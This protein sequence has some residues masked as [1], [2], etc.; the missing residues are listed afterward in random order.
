M[1]LSRFLNSL[2][3]QGFVYW[4]KVDPS[5]SRSWRKVGK[6]A[7][8]RGFEVKM[9]APFECQHGC[10]VAGP[11]PLLRYLCILVFLTPETWL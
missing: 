3:T 6:E 8:A 2:K 10:K 4:R 11:A 9:E 5:D 1:I 7:L